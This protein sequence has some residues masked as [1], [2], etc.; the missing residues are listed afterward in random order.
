M[1]SCSNRPRSRVWVLQ[2]QNMVTV[3]KLYFVITNSFWRLYL[4]T[5]VLLRY[6]CGLPLPLQYEFA[7]NCFEPNLKSLLPISFC[8]VVGTFKFTGKQYNYCKV[9]HYC[10][11]FLHMFCISKIAFCKLLLSL[12]GLYQTSY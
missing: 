8:S 3:S 2:P 6:F 5:V 10:V 1:Y 7:V 12:V 11:V 9:Y 4:L